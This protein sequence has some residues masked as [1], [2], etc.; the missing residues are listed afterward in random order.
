MSSFLST[1][2]YRKALHQFHNFLN[3]FVIDC[4]MEQIF[5]E[6]LEHLESRIFFYLFQLFVRQ[7]LWS[8][9]S[10]SV[11]W[12]VMITARKF[13]RKML[14]QHLTYELSVLLSVVVAVD[15]TK[16]CKG[17][18]KWKRRLVQCSR[19]NKTFPKFFWNFQKLSKISRSFDF[20]KFQKKFRIF[21][22]ATQLG[23]HFVVLERPGI[24]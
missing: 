4:L 21:Q 11:E 6:Q 13:L 24:C 1:H 2:S 8:L 16:D 10:E 12:V 9:C 18:K 22:Y 3:A 7:L 14:T 15:S 19:W 20:L 17:V 23:K 5:V